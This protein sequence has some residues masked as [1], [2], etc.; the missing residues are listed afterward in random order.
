MNGVGDCL[1]MGMNSDSVYLWTSPVFHYNGWC[2]PWA[3]TAVGATHIC[4]RKVDP[5]EIIRLLQSES[6]P[7]MCAAPIVLIGIV[8]HPASKN[9]SLNR[10]LKI[11]VGGA[12]PSPTIIEQME[13]VPTST[14]YMG[15]RRFM[16]RIRYVHGTRSGIN[17]RQ[18]N[19][20]P[21]VPGRVL[22]ML[23]ASF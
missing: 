20:R 6:V 4:L 1:E 11:A 13:R 2:F 14:T 15:L 22:P 16:D 23:S 18:V 17:C 10:P 5:A 19:V 7:H 8:N 21:F 12:P 9:I 3:V